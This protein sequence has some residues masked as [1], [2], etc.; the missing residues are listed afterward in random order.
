MWIVVAVVALA[1]HGILFDQ[2]T[3]APAPATRRDRYD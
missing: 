1:I 2:P 3:D